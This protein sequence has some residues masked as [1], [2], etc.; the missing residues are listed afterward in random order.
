MKH[1]F[2]QVEALPV[3]NSLLSAKSYFSDHKVSGLIEKQINA[4]RTAVLIIG[5]GLPS[6]AYT[7]EN[8]ISTPISLTEF[9]SLN[10]GVSYFRAIKLPDVAGRLTWLALES[11][12]KNK[13]SIGSDDAWKKQLN[14]WRQVRWNGLIEITKIT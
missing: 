11:Q 6:I 8:G 5:G 10:E 7:L 14:Q 12:A 1:F 13:Y 3:H 2:S 9:S 4:D